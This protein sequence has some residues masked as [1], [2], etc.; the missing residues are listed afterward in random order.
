[1][2]KN[3][4]M[5]SNLFTFA[6]NNAEFLNDWWLRHRQKS[7]AGT[8][9]KNPGIET[10]LMRFSEAMA[11]P[12]PGSRYE[13]PDVTNETFAATSQA[14]REACQLANVKPTARQASKF[15]ARRG[16]AYKTHKQYA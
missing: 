5:S 1:M 8:Y 16:T 13:T 15:R 14:F 2:A 10:I 4:P 9:E 6:S 11:S 3:R 12:N 7:D